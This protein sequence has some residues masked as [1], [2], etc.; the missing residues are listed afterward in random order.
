ME[1]KKWYKNFCE[2][3]KDVTGIFNDELLY[4]KTYEEALSV[5]EDGNYQELNKESFLL[6]FHTKNIFESV[7]DELPKD[8]VNL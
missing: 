4:K 2:N 5:Y 8:G 6:S 7:I 1:F 3:N